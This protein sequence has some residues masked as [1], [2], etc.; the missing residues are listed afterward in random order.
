MSS[1]VCRRPHNTFYIS[2]L[3]LKECFLSG[4]IYQTFTQLT[5]T[6]HPAF[7]SL[8]SILVYYMYR[9]KKVLKVLR[10]HQGWEFAHS[11]ICSFH[12]NQMSDCERFA[13]I[14]QRK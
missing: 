14:A 1:L 11:L 5:H 8:Y 3:N 2:K 6:F 9:S 10:E 12:S 4:Q 7:L 13:Q